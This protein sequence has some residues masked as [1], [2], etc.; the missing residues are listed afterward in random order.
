MYRSALTV[1]VA[2]AVGGCAPKKW[3]HPSYDEL[4]SEKDLY[5]CMKEHSYKN[6]HASFGEGGFRSGTRV[7]FSNELVRGCMASKGYEQVKE[8]ESGGSGG[9]WVL[10]GPKEDAIVVEAGPHLGA[11]FGRQART[12]ASVGS[13]G[14]PQIEQSLQGS[15]GWGQVWPSVGLHVR[16]GQHLDW[17]VEGGVRGGPAEA[18]VS[19]GDTSDDSFSANC[20]EQY[21]YNQSLVAFASTGVH[22]RAP[23]FPRLTGHVEFGAQGLARIEGAALDMEVYDP[24]SGEHEQH[25]VMVPGQAGA[26]VP[27]VR[28]GVGLDIVHPRPV[29][30]AFQCSVQSTIGLPNIKQSAGE[31]GALLR[32]APVR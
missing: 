7:D 13:A 10:A 4:R 2:L 27:Y 18:R 23:G 14:Q 11:G 6:K 3:V 22:G 17:T 31:C 30:F 25:E 12:V 5:E 21:Q 15:T 16:G 1:L 8:R 24:N 19:C 29:G 20:N 32:W 28:Y 26:M 9:D